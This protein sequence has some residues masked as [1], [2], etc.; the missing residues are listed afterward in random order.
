MSLWFTPF[1]WGSTPSS[2][3]APT[4]P[5]PVPPVWTRIT[6]GGSW[7]RAPG[8]SLI[9]RFEHVYA[10]VPGPAPYRGQNLVFRVQ[11]EYPFI[12]A[13]ENAVTITSAV[14]NP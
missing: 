3:T 4:P 9:P 8:I 6:A 5:V 13:S 10:E 7:S 2:A 12:I 1:Q 14:S 11:S